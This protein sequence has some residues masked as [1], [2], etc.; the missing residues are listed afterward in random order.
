MP[1][2]TVKPVYKDHT[3]D[4]KILAVVDRWSLIRGHLSYVSSRWD[5]EMMV[6]I[7]GVIC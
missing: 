1:K 5:P 4:P 6:A 3:W 2:G 7:G